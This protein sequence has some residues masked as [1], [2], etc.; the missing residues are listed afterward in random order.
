MRRAAALLLV[1]VLAAAL[2]PAAACAQG[3][4]KTVRL[5]WHEPPYFIT[6]Q[7]GRWSGYS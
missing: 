1:L 7:Y 6:D 5:G 4:R 3:E 2:L